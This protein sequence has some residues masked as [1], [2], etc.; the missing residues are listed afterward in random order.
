MFVHQNSHT[1]SS[2]FPFK[3][4]SICY[5]L[6]LLALVACTKVEPVEP[7]PALPMPS[8]VQFALD[9]LSMDEGFISYDIDL[10]LSPKSSRNGKLTILLEDQGTAKYLT[11][12]ITIPGLENGKLELPVQAGDTKVSIRII[13]TDDDLHN[14][15]RSIKLTLQQNEYTH[16]KP[17]GKTTLLVNLADNENFSK[18]G[19]TSERSSVFEN[20]RNGTQVTLKLE[21]AAYGNGY[22]DVA[23]NLNGN[24]YGEHFVT[25]PVAV[26]GKIRVPVA[27]GSQTA[28]IKVIPINDFFLNNHRIIGF[29][30]LESSSNLKSAGIADHELLILEDGEDN[31]ITLKSIRESYKGSDI[32]YL[33]RT[34]IYGRVV[35]RGDNVSPKQIYIQD[36]TGGIAVEFTGNH[37]LPMGENV[38]INIE[39]G[40]VSNV[41]EVLTIKGIA[42]NAAQRNGTDAFVVP[43]LTLK[44]LYENPAT[45][46]GT[47]VT[48]KGVSFGAPQYNNRIEGN[49]QIYD[50]GYIA[51]VRT[52]S[53]A[54]FKNLPVPTGKRDVTGVLIWTNNQYTILP[55]QASD[56]R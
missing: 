40:T 24:R 8:K 6:I 29:K 25:I 37:N 38:T 2:R 23:L 50:A 14:Q 43:E 33:L 32:F 45:L 49:V 15:P 20:D 52:E 47:L 51:T 44:Y 22:V 41:N 10:L 39:G 26:N 28:D 13:S 11:D 34:T 18:V 31:R 9:N 48:V 46:E 42:N 5:A 56:I 55:Q 36:E 7:G 16:I 35:S 21:P 1:M 17:E 54:S 12:Y 53:F 3:S 30:L 27:Q 4:I 19:F